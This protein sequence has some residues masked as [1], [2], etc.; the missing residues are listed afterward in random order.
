MAQCTAFATGIG[1]M[2]GAMIAPFRAQS[3]LAWGFSMGANWFTLSLPFFALREA[4]MHVNHSINNSRQIENWKLRDKD[5]FIASMG[6]GTVVGLG[7]GYIWRG[8]VAMPAGALMYGIVAGSLQLAVTAFRRQRQEWAY[9]YSQRAPPPPPSP[10]S[11]SL[12]PSNKGIYKHFPEPFH[13]EARD[14]SQDAGWDPVGEFVMYLRNKFKAHVEVVPEWASPILNALDLEYRERL[15]I[16]IASLEG[17]VGNLRAELRSLANGGLWAI[18]G[19]ALNDPFIYIPNLIG[20]LVGLLQVIIKAY[21]ELQI[22]RQKVKPARGEEV[23][24]VADELEG[25]DLEESS[26]LE[27]GSVDL[28]VGNQGESAEVTKRKGKGKAEKGAGKKAVVVG[29]ASLE[30]VI[31]NLEG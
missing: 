25:D 23:D 28:E 30:S 14:P 6:S 9:T 12:D 10:S 13:A 19:F 20:A 24:G 27:G 3:S 17:E 2:S 5:E 8:P 22:K 18:Y 4:I 1:A 31:K 7:A 26:T 29:T 21:L 15:N 16:K 11:S